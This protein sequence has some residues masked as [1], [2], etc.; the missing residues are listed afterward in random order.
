MKHCIDIIS[1]SILCIVLKSYIFI[2]RIHIYSY[3]FMCCKC[4][5][6][7]GYWVWYILHA[8]GVVLWLST[9]V[10]QVGLCNDVAHVLA[11]YRGICDTPWLTSV[12][13]PCGS[14]PEMLY[15]KVFW[16]WMYILLHI[17]IDITKFSLCIFIVTWCVFTYMFVDVS[18][19]ISDILGIYYNIQTVM[20]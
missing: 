19:I 7:Q 4:I 13:C 3:I 9:F 20:L 10:C 17:Y 1:H 11:I 18:V 6:W 16:Y 15:V 12:V 14:L 8:M 2:I 5:L